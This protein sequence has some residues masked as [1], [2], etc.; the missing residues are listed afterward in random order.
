[1]G[2]VG[3]KTVREPGFETLLNTTVFA[4]VEGQDGDAATGVETVADVA[5]EGVE[6]GEL[7]VDGDAQGL[8]NTADRQVGII[9]TS[10]PFVECGADSFG[11]WFGAGKS[12]AGQREG[13]H[14]RVGFVG[15]FGQKS[16]ELGRAQFCEQVGSGLAALRVHPH[17]ERAVA[18]GG[19]TARWIVQ[20]HRGDAEV[21]E[22]DV[23]TGDL[24]VRQNFWQASEITPVDTN[25]IG[26]V[27]KRAQP[28]FCF[29]QL[30]RI[31]IESNEAAAGRDFFEQSAGVPAKAKRAIGDTIAGFRRED[32]QDLIDHDGPM[33]PGWSFAGLEDFGDGVG[34]TFG[35]V[36]F[37]F[38]LEPT[39]ILSRIARAALMFDGLWWRWRFGLIGHSECKM[40]CRSPFLKC[41]SIVLKKLRRAQFR[42]ITRIVAVQNQEHP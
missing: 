34:V 11:E 23:D 36:L 16:F 28:L 6:R 17:V 10:S 40:A 1:M 29:R 14:M 5:Q 26:T 31:S 37:V 22:D 8:E 19:E 18:F 9:T 15:V 2:N 38:L 27:A 24:A 39:R 42:F 30:N 25:D 41:N 35:I 12:F 4:G 3:I 13:E 32:L 33:C 20:L 7:V 21:G